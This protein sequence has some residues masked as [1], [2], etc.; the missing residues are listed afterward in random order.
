[1]SRGPNWVAAIENTSRVTEK[2]SAST[3]LTVPRITPRITRASSMLP[4]D[5]Q[6]GSAKTPALAYQSRVRVAANRTRMAEAIANG[7]G[8][9]L[10]PGTALLTRLAPVMISLPP[11]TF[12]DK[13]AKARLGRPGQQ[14]NRNRPSC[15]GVI[16][17]QG[18]PI[19]L[20]K[21]FGAPSHTRALG[22]AGDAGR[23]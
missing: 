14:L 6:R 4:T 19:G 9:R 16:R 5:S 20:R 1:M 23:S 22:G 15:V 13:P 12:A 3:V 18:I 11:D 17:V 8:S 21:R 10:V 2:S 7:T